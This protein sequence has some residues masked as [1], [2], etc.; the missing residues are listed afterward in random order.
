MHMKKQGH[1]YRTATNG[2]EAL[3]IFQSV[4]NVAHKTEAVTRYS[5]V[6]C[7]APAAFDYILMDISMPIMDGLE[8]TRRIRAH[9][10]RMRSEMQASRSAQCRAATIIA[11][12]GLANAQAQGEAFS[13]GVDIFLPKPVKL[14]ELTRIMAA[15]GNER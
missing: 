11:L 2:L 15:E 7:E 1:R 14:A 12:T 3:D 8:S 5:G 13:S 4:S 9:E 10:R 6:R